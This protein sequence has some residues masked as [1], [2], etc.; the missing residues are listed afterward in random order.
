MSGSQDQFRI[1]VNTGILLV[2][3][4]LNRET[5][6]DYTLLVLATDRGINQL[7]GNCTVFIN[8]TDVNDVDPVFDPIEPQSVAEGKGNAWL[9]LN[10]VM[11]L[12]IDCVYS[13]AF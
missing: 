8:I 4:V 5:V 13:H 9:E 12:I 6:D 3:D 2:N 11:S 1:E 7:E 10:L